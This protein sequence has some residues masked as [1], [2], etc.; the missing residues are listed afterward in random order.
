MAWEH[1]LGHDGWLGGG[2]GTQTPHMSSYWRQLGS[3]FPVW[4][5][6]S[7]FAGHLGTQGPQ[8]YSYWS[9]LGSH[10]PVC[11]ARSQEAGHVGWARLSSVEAGTGAGLR[12]DSSVGV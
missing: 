5:A 3:Q 9:Q 1:L 6:L 7:H 4:T 12:P 8:R 10:C 2:G 11:M